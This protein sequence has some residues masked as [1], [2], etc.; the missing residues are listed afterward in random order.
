MAVRRY[1]DCQRM[2]RDDRWKLIAYNASGERNTQL[3]DLANDPDEITN[4]ADDP[5]LAQQRAHLEKRLLEARKQFGDPVDFD[6]GKQQI[7]SSAPTLFRTA[8]SPLGPASRKMGSQPQALVRL[9][10][11]CPMDG[12]EDQV[13][14]ERRLTIDLNLLTIKIVPANTSS[15]SSGKR[16]RQKTGPAKPTTSPIF[17]A[18]FWNILGYK[19]F[20]FLRARRSS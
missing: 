12:M 5:K 20:G 10:V 17:V 19:T 3:F 4:L 18:P 1:R 13:S 14:G 8:I 2:V 15:E 7:V 6:K 11:R 16:R 9:R